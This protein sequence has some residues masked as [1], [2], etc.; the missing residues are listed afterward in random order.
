MKDRN[1]DEFCEG[2]YTI[3]WSAD[4]SAII[5]LDWRFHYYVWE[6]ENGFIVKEG[7]L[8]KDEIGLVE[9]VIL[10]KDNVNI[11][12]N[13]QEGNLWIIRQGIAKKV[14]NSCAFGNLKYLDSSIFLAKNCNYTTW[15]TFSSDTGEM[16]EELVSIEGMEVLRAEFANVDFGED[17]D[18]KEW[19]ISNGGCFSA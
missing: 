14:K 15:R 13:T 10:G 8:D 6:T 3:Q 11:F 18:L 2:L 19:I 9:S 5:G 7:V 1:Q 12:F 16:I 17:E 4:G